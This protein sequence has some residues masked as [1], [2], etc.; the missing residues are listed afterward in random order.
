MLDLL[1]DILTR[2]SLK[3][4]LYF[5]TS[6]TPPWGVQVPQL[7]SVCRFHFAHRGDCMLRIQATGETFMVAQGDLVIIP[8]GAAHILYC[9]HTGPDESL[10]LDEVFEKSG[11]RGEGVLVY[12][13]DDDT[14]S[15]QMICGHFSFAEGS[16]HLIFDRL[17]SC[18]H[19]KDYGAEAGAWMEAT[20]RVIGGEAGVTRLGGDLIALK[21]SEAIFAQAIR[22]WLERQDGEGNGLAGFADPQLSRSLTAFHGDPAGSWSVESL[23]RIAGLSRTSFAQHFARKMGV[24]PMQYVT[25]WRMQIARQGLAERKLNVSEAAAL[26]GYASDSAFS[27]VFKKEVGI[28][29]ASFRAGR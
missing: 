20:L 28:S 27:R 17:P 8:H 9:Q 6:F 10:P 21:M 1:S 4:T 11:Y 3:G 15:T 24:T 19:I 5:R 14:R 22:T 25:D 12:G 7:D 29:P 2:L 16:R 13:G 18:I 23:A 26:A